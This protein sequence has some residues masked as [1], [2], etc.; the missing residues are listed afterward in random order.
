MM[1]TIT[2]TNR[3]NYTSLIED[4][5]AKGI[6][7]NGLTP[8]NTDK[9]SVTHN[10]NHCT[11][12]GTP[13]KK[14][15]IHVHVGSNTHADQLEDPD[16]GLDYLRD[17]VTQ[18]SNASVITIPRLHIP[19]E[20]GELAGLAEHSAADS[21]EG[22]DSPEVTNITPE[23]LKKVYSQVISILVY[24]ISNTCITM[25]FDNFKVCIL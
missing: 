12:S 20:T 14:S 8:V 2:S 25:L 4:T 9:D 11:L 5:G 17:N 23:K 15:L 1:T 22:A 18:T 10:D 3:F 7:E 19:G 13:S 16:K 21:E 24:I 6:M